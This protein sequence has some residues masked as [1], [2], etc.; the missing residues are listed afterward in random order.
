MKEVEVSY[1]QAKAW[2]T[3]TETIEDIALIEAVSRAGPF[4][5]KVIDRK[6]SQ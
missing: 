5:G 4:K 3:A 2:I 6:A 1:E